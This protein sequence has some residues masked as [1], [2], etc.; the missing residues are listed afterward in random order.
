MAASYPRTATLHFSLWNLSSCNSSAGLPAVYSDPSFG[1]W[2]AMSSSKVP[3]SEAS[4]H[5]GGSCTT[6]LLV[7][8]QLPLDLVQFS[9]FRGRGFS[10]PSA[11]FACPALRKWFLTRKY[12]RLTSVDFEVWAW[13]VLRPW[14]CSAGTARILETSQLISTTYTDLFLDLID[15][16]FDN[17]CSACPFSPGHSLPLSFSKL[18]RSTMVA[19]SASAAKTSTCDSIQSCECY[20]SSWRRM[21]HVV[22]TLPV[23][24]LQTCRANASERAM[25][26]TPGEIRQTPRYPQA[27]TDEVRRRSGDST[28]AEQ[29]ARRRPGGF[30]GLRRIMRAVLLQ[31]P[32][33]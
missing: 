1:P 16:D 5:T 30:D 15:S 18:W 9:D 8:A 28:K 3:S 7:P 20:E 12:W 4:I 21:E 32:F 24:E 29:E 31:S 13:L 17:S 19:S 2:T 6:F 23:S 33:F 10:S 14:S 25:G 26:R 27:K 22:C 11:A